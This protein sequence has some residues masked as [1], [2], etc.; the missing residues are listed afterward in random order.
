[1]VGQN[2]QKMSSTV[3]FTCSQK[4]AIAALWAYGKAVGLGRLHS[5]QAP[6]DEEIQYVM[7]RNYVDYLAGK[8]IK[9]KL[10]HWPTV[11]GRC[12]DRENGQGAMAKV[13]RMLAE[14]GPVPAGTGVTKQLNAREKAE[15]IANAN[16]SVGVVMK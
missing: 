7:D 10:E 6:S 11:D 8:P 12:Y 14:S 2:T 13:A 4:D 9:I 5:S 15:V 1:M 16:A 3:T